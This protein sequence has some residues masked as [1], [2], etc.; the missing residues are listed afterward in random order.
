MDTFKLIL[1]PFLLFQ[2][3]LCFSALFDMSDHS[4]FIRDSNGNYSQVSSNGSVR[5]LTSN[6]ALSVAEKVNF[7]TSKGLFTTDLVRT[8]AVDVA[9]IGKTVR[10]VAVAGGPVGMTI[11]AVSLVCELTS[12]CEQAGSW[13]YTPPDTITQIKALS[14]GW[15]MNSRNSNLYKAGDFQTAA[16]SYFD[17]TFWTLSIESYSITASNVEVYIKLQNGASIAHD[18][19]NFHGSFTPNSTTPAAPT[20]SNW[21]TAEPLLNDSRFTPELHAKDQPIPVQIPGIPT[22][23]KSPIDKRTTTLKDGSGNTTGT[24]DEITEAQIESPTSAE[25]PTGNPNLIKITEITTKNTYNTSNVLTSTTTTTTGG[26]EQPQP[27]SFEIDID[28]MQDQPLEEKTIPGIFSHTSWG[29]GSCP[30]DR[31]VSYH[32]GTLNLTFQPACDA[33]IALQPLVVILAGIA[34]LFIISGAVRN[35]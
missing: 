25:N 20:T 27:Q 14:N 30:G 10:S 18:Y 22:P 2:S 17:C 19:A 9:R 28:N 7:Q 32:Y 23:I 29:S 1:L 24:E 5:S 15:F 26:T 34:A 12:I 11:A 33:A 21:D 13:L 4:G 35:D 16:C 8:A 3:G 6:T 31:S